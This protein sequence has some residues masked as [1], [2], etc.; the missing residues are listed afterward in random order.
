LS[1]AY[2][3]LASGFT[4]KYRSLLLTKWQRALNSEYISCNHEFIL[5]ELFGDTF[6][7]RDWHA[8]G[9]PKDNISI[10]N[11]IIMQ[12]TRQYVVCVDPQMQAVAWIKS[13]WKLEGKQPGDHIRS[14][15]IRDVNFKKHLEIA[16]ELG[17]P[18]L[19]SELP[20]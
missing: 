20:E 3:T 8:N 16:I 1:A 14:T 10:D 12:K 9:L 13:Q 4:Q 5:Q 7:I 17:V 19:I 15:T 2:V 6:T 18:M 11:A